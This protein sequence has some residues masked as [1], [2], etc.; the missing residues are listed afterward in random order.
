M[1]AASELDDELARFEE[2]VAAFKKLSLS[3]KKALDRA[4]AMLEELAQSEQSMGTQVQA[5]V[6]A[7][8]A[9][10]DRQ[11]ERVTVV[12]EK[13]EELKSRSVEF[14]DLIVQFEALG[15]GA[16][17]LNARL[18]SDKPEIVDVLDEVSA[19]GGKAEALLAQAREKGFD[20]V[21][22][23]ADGLK[24]QLTALRGKLGNKVTPS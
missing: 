3:S 15:T 13:A 9:T 1:H 14:R 4:G 17:A 16:A 24:Q 19:L 21:A 6:A 11:L 8:Q 5:L 12:R 20:D 18:Q 22:H 10:R 23:L 2:G 7:I